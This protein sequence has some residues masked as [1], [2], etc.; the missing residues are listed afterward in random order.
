ML[1]VAPPD[2]K[3]AGADFGREL[4]RLRVAAT[5][6]LRGSKRVFKPHGQCGLELSD[7]LPYLGTVADDLLL[8]RSMHSE[9]FNHHPGQLLM[10]CGASRFG[11]PTIG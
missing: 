7:Y 4:Y 10:Q 11:L 5:A 8:V 2:A 9:E 1:L 3:A 6:T